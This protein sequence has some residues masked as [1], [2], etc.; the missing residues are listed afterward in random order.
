[1]NALALHR[2][3]GALA[4]WLDSQEHKDGCM[5]GHVVQHGPLAGNKIP[6]SCGLTDLQ[7]A[8]SRVRDTA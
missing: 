1:M 2:F 7:K 3:F 4:D 5:F 6:C 8:T